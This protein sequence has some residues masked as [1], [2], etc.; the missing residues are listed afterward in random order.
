V[1]DY[2]AAK[3]AV[4][5]IINKGKKNILAIFGNKKVSITKARDTSRFLL[6][7]PKFVGINLI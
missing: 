5:T 2:Q 4:E 3:I 6:T 1:S 7:V